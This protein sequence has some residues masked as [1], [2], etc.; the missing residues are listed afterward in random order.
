V[1][2]PFG[3]LPDGRQAWL[4]TICGGGLRAELTDYGA[5]LVRLYVPDRN[6]EYADVVLG[7]DDAVGYANDMFCIGATVGRNS[8]RVRGGQFQL[9]GKTIVLSQNDGPNNLHSGPDFFHQRFW[10]VEDCQEDHIIF[11]L[12]SPDGDQGFPG[13]AT[14]RL[15]F[16][17]KTPG[18]LQICYE[19]VSDQDTVFNMTNHSYFNLA[20]HQNPEKP[21]S[22]VLMIPSN[23]FL[24]SDSSCMTTG[25]IRSVDGTPMDFRTPKPL[26]RDIDV[27]Y[28]SLHPMGGYDHCFVTEEAMCAKLLEPESG[29]CLQV[30]TDAPGVHLFCGND[31]DLTGKDNALYPPRSGICL[32]TEFFPDGVNHPDWPQPIVKAGAL[33]QSTTSFVFSVV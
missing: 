11:R 5:N 15:S 30:Y 33:W 2:R 29:R 27:D 21:M 18:T 17:L 1:K 23:R 9:N 26:S 7:Y 3:T 16:T 32:E 28:E 10:Q 19:A 6:G 4:Y 14:I 13:N 20:G 8:N 22:H 31:L 25:E 12:D 24:V